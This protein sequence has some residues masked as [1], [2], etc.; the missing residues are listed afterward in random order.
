M[1]DMR[2]AYIGKTITFHCKYDHKFKTHTKVFYRLN[3]GPVHVLNS[4]QSSQSSEEKF[5]LSDSQ[6]DHFNVTIRD[7]STTDDGVYLCGVE[8][9]ESDDQPSET[10]ITH[11][12]FIKEIDMNVQSQ[13]TSVQVE[14][15]ISKSVFITCTFPQKFKEN[16]KFI[17]KDS[18]QKIPVKKQNKWFRH[19]KVHMYDD[20]SEGLLKVFISDLTTADEATYRCGVNITDDDDPFT[21]IKLTVN[22][23]DHFHAS[24]KS[25]AVIGES[26]KLTC[27]YSEKHDE[28]I[29]HICKE[30]NG[31]IC[32]NIH[33]SELKSFEFSDSTAGVFTVIISNFTG[34]E[35]KPDTNM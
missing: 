3:V 8:R 13:I 16:K 33:S 22:Q 10:S 7:I 28:T 34:V 31:T 12:T 29:K 35:Q 30:N 21:E 9:H 23:V 5:I 24:T 17:Q 27:S 11:I 20:T 6:K 32:Q 4:S 19:D 1:S 25:A 26:V 2:T 18:S 15:Y 14:A